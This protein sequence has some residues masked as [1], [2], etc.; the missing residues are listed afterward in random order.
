MG[1][2]ARREPRAHRWNTI[3]RTRCKLA[4]ILTAYIRSIPGR[5]KTTRYPDAQVLPEN[6]HA[7]RLAGK[8]RRWEDAHSWEATVTWLD[9]GLATTLYS[10]DNMT[11]CVRAGRVYSIGDD[12]EVSV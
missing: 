10:F 1:D 9:G 6:I 2:N 8:A 7:M 5:D 12:G 3:G 11:T 4:E